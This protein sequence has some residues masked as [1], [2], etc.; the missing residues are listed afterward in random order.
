[1]EFPVYRKYR[2]SKTYFKIYS[3]EEFEEVKMMG[4]TYQVH[5]YKAE[6]LPDRNLIED[7]I[8]QKDQYYESVSESEF[9]SF[10]EYCRGHLQK[11]E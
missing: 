3:Y 6:K 7:L 5:H 9:E 10:R 8:H 4:G 2:D 11:L 1:M